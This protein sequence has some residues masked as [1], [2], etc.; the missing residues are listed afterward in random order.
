MAL[1][2][3]VAFALLR[4]RREARGSEPQSWL[5]AL[6]GL[7]FIR[8][9]PVILGAITLDLFAILFGGAT[10]LMPVYAAT[11]LHVGPTGLGYLRSA[12]AVGAAV[13]AAAIFKAVTARHFSLR[14]RL[15]PATASLAA[16]GVQ[17]PPT[18]FPSKE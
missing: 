17:R 16:P 7:A 1:V 6:A 14:R 12:P 13:V 18:A 4:V 8:S 3:T 15:D 2:S 9:R 10:A 5:T 11:I